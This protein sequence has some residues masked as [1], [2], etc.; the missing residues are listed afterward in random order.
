M[1]FEHFES[2][3]KTTKLVTVEQ[4][5][6]LFPACIGLLPILNNIMGK[7]FAAMENIR[8]ALSILKTEC[9]LILA[10]CNGDEIPIR[11][12]LESNKRKE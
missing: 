4:I 2:S 8:F 6:P 12:Y 5:I 10:H 3:S 9:C 7:Y 1:Q 11:F